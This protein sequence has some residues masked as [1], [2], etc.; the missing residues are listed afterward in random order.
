MGPPLNPKNTTSES[1]NVLMMMGG[2]DMKMGAP[3]MGVGLI[4]V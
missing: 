4:N 1:V 3:K 2:G